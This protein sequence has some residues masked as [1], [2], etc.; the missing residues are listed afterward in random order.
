MAEQPEVA[1][2]SPSS[3]RRDVLLVVAGMVSMTLSTAASF[4]L[5]VDAGYIPEQAVLVSPLVDGLVLGFGIAV[6]TLVVSVLI[7]LLVVK[8][9]LWR[10]SHWLELAVEDEQEV[11]G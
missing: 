9:L 4:V 10:Y 1:D 2:W 7:A 3:R 5:G 11:D 8:Y 6:A